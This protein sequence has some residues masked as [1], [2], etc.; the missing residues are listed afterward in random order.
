MAALSPPPPS[1]LLPAVPLPLPLLL[2]VDAVGTVTFTEKEYNRSG[3][4]ENA[5]TTSND[6]YVVL[7]YGPDESAAFTAARAFAAVADA[8]EDDD[9]EFAAPTAHYNSP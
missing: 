5:G 6:E 9:D 3:T 1:L 7:L 8:D 4:S 2:L